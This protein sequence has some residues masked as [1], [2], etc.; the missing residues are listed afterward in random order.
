[1]KKLPPS[2]LEP[3]SF[4]RCRV[5]YAYSTP[6]PGGG[7]VK[8]LTFG[9]GPPAFQ[10]LGILGQSGSV[11]KLHKWRLLRTPIASNSS[12]V[13]KASWA[14]AFWTIGFGLRPAGGGSGS[15]ES[16]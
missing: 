12:K 10:G 14:S 13:V 8:S 16:A 2:V 11:L 6:E 15:P 4:I 3:F 5:G 1:M 7:S 9:A